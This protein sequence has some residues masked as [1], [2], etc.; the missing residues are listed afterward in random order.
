MFQKKPKLIDLSV[1]AILP[2][3]NRGWKWVNSPR[4]IFYRQQNS[5]QR[6]KLTVPEA[7]EL[8]FKP[9]QLGWYIWSYLAE[10]VAFDMIKKFQNPSL[11]TVTDISCCPTNQLPMTLLKAKNLAYFSVHMLKGLFVSRPWAYNWSK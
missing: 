11:Q 1:R 9:S 10:E 8:Q 6:L 3:R 2:G 7:Y 5:A 4:H